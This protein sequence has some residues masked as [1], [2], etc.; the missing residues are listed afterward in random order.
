MKMRMWVALALAVAMIAML[1]AG[2]A[3]KTVEAE[4]APA[5]AVEEKA[6]AAGVGEAGISEAERQRL[7]AEQQK[8]DKAY[9]VLTEN[10]IYF[11]F[12]RYDLKPEAKETLQAKAQIM[13]DFP[14]WKMLIEGNC[15]ERGTEEYNL[16]LGERRARAAYEFLVLLGVDTERL[17]IVSNGEEKP[18]C[19]ESNET[20][21]AKNR[22]DEFKAFR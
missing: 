14:G 10:V 12:D 15:D 20:C 17:K 16:A 11:D 9:G 2:C 8:A 18:V 1:G 6:P 7:A 21:W 22:R 5:A 3:K 19:T 13:K 4:Q